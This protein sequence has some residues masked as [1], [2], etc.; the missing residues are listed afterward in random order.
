MSKDVL[1]GAISEKRTEQNNEFSCRVY[2]KRTCILDQDPAFF[3]SAPGANIADIEKG[4]EEGGSVD[5][6]AR[7]IVAFRT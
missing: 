4:K 2:S 5:E 1:T 6:I 7:L 3:V